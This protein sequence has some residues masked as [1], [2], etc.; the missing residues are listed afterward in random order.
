ML[1]I[2]RP[3]YEAL[4]AYLLYAT[5][6]RVLKGPSSPGTSWSAATASSPPRHTKK[7]II[8]S[9][10]R[11]TAALLFLLA[12]VVPM[13]VCT[14]LPASAQPDSSTVSR[15][16]FEQVFPGHSGFYTYDGFITA[17]G[18]S[19][20]RREAAAFLANVDHET[21]GLTITEEAPSMRS[22]Y[23]DSS[24]PYGCPAGR[25]AYFGRG[26][27]QLS[28]NANYKDAG[29]ALGLDLLNN[30]GPRRQRSWRGLGD[31]VLVLEHLCPARCRLRRHHRVINGPLECDGGN[32]AQVAS[33]VN[34]YRGIADILGVEPGGKLSC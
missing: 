6:Y 25:N 9:Y 8:M 26:P 29:D 12:T 5:T 7:G 24:K 10:R 31:G 23:C 15:A 27:I 11:R 22:G 16:E 4:R 2:Y 20:S 21:G 28:W 34:A 32:P 13:S 19:L 14:S 18:G 1:P 3:I 30:P 33:R 17:G